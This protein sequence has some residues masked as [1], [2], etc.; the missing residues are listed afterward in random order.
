MLKYRNRW[1][2]ADSS[3][4]GGPFS[5]HRY[6]PYF[7]CHYRTTEMLLLVLL[8]SKGYSTVSSAVFIGSD[9][10]QQNNRSAA[11]CRN[12]RSWQLVMFGF[13][14]LKI[15]VVVWRRSATAKVLIIINRS[16]WHRH[17]RGNY[18]LRLSSTEKSKLKCCFFLKFYFKMLWNINRRL[19]YTYCCYCR[20]RFFTQP[21]VFEVA[22][23]DSI[24]TFFS[25]APSNSFPV[26]RM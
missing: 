7:Q 6:V 19:V 26:F 21:G 18:H 5:N 15:V 25:V 17:N 14:G 8:T 1:N 24:T 4:Y 2:F 3:Q 23:F 9:V 11:P 10:Q 22:W 12:T 20:H 13:R 16:V